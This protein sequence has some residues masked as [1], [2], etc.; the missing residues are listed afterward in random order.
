MMNAVYSVTRDEGHEK[1]S[2]YREKLHREQAERVRP[3]LKDLDRVANWIA[4]TDNYVRSHPTPERMGDN[5][6]RLQIEAFD[7]FRLVGPKRAIIRVGEPID[8]ADHYEEYRKDRRG[9]V[10][11]CV[12][13]L[14]QA[15]QGLLDSSRAQAAPGPKQPG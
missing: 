8:L 5:I 13:M 4:V 10:N 6:R 11:R 14:E 2:P 3:L 1:W 15:V 12:G 9:V 7:E